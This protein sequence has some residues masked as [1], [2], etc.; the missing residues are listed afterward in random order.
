LS[1]ITVCFNSEATIEKTFAS[2]MTQSY[3]NIEYIVIDGQST[4]RTL[5][6][7]EQ[8]RSGID[9]LVSEPDNGLYDAMNK[10]IDLA[11]G[12]VIAFI[13]SDD[14]FQTEDSVSRLMAP[15]EDTEVD[16]V[17]SDLVYVNNVNKIVRYWRSCPF[18]QGMFGKGWSP[19]HPTFYVRK[20]FYKIL[21]GFNCQLQYGN[22]VDLMMR[23][24]EK[25]KLKAVYVPRVS[26]RMLI[27][28]VS[29]RSFKTIWV[30]NASTI[31]LAKQYGIPCNS[32]EYI[33]KK[34]YSRFTQ[35]LLRPKWGK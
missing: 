18:R 16:C 26:V 5:E 12:E 25:A 11:S 13:N 30:Q 14:T 35:I 23:F 31:S 24:L 8:Y 6:I 20:K 32:F 33:F 2:A 9:V 7:I 27:G 1:L 29:N 10:G 34:F 4:D 3:E 17:Y 28:G 21:G 15:F 19:A 22:D